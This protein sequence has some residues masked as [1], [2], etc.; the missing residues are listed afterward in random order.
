[1]PKTKKEQAY[2]IEY[3]R[4]NYKRWHADI[5]PDLHA[6]LEAAREDKR[7]SRREYLEWLMAKAEEGE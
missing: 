7:M 1:M 5:R 2:A 4:I 3:N 6:A